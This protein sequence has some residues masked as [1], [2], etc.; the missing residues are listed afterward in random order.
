MKCHRCGESMTLFVVGD[1]YCPAC[2]REMQAREQADARRVQFRVL[3]RFS[4]AKDLT[5]Y[6]GS[7]A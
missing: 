4:R 3:P 6:G 7:A 1:D 5:P 2:K